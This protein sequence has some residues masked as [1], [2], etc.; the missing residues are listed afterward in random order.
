MQDWAL[1]AA[2]L[3]V[4]TGHGEHCTLEERVGRV[5]AKEPAGH[6]ETAVQ[7]T[8]PAVGA[9]KPEAHGVQVVAGD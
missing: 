8:R 9:K 7:E 1:P 4:L 5:E 3:K 2:A 6:R